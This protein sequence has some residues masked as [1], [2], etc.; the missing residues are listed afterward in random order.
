MVPPLVRCVLLSF[1]IT[2]YTSYPPF[3]SPSPFYSLPPSSLSLSATSCPFCYSQCCICQLYP[4]T[5]TSP[6]LPPAAAAAASQ[7]TS[8]SIVNRYPL[9]PQTSALPSTPTVTSQSP[10]GNGLVIFGNNRPLNPAYIYPPQPPRD[11]FVFLPDELSA[12]K[13]YSELQLVLL[14]DPT[15]SAQAAITTPT[16]VP[17][18]SVE[19]VN[20]PATCPAF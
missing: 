11:N 3:P 16:I 13:R 17:E 8:I 5:S 7:L 14:Q 15:L 1:T 20:T 12:A 10:A 2:F 6:F 9:S 18:D 19:M 4:S